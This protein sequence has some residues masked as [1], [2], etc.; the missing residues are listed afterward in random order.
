MRKTA[1]EPEMRAVVLS[2]QLEHENPIDSEHC[3]EQLIDSFNER[4]NY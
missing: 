4:T 1:N 3:I 2:T